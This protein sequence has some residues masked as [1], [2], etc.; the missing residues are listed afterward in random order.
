MRSNR[1]TISAAIAT[2]LVSA[3]LYPVFSGPAWFWA[4]AGATV[5]IAA[6]GT[7]T[8]LRRLPV[9]AC[10]LGGAAG[11]LLYLNLVFARSRS[12]LLVIPTPSSLAY[13]W[14]LAGQGLN[15]AAAYAPPAPELAGLVLLA[16]AGIG[17]TALL[18][19]LIAVR[20][21]SAAL[22][23]L[24]LLLLFCEPFTLSISRGWLGT[25]A[26]FCLAAAGYLTI[27]GAEGRERV[28]EWEQPLP[29]QPAAS[30]AARAPDTRALTAAGRRVG[31]ASVIVALCVPMFV[32]GL[33]V[34]RLFGGSA[35]IGGA[36][37]A[38][39]GA[40]FP[41]IQDVVTS[42]LRE[43][44]AVPVL[45]YRTSAAQPGY[46][47]VYVLD[48]LTD[49]GWQPFAQPESLV[50]V[51]PRLPPAPGITST[52]PVSLVTTDI[53]V[54]PGVPPDALAALAAPYPAVSVR[55]AAGIVRAD[56]GTLMIFDDGARL[57]GLS[58]TVTSDRV[59]PGERALA[60]VP[61]AAPAQIRD[62]YLQVPRAY[63]AL[64]G[65]ARDI[66]A[67]ARSPYAEAVALQDYFSDG[68][69]AY[70]LSA[71]A[72]TTE[73]GLANFLETT[74]TGY[75]VQ[76]ASAMAVLARLLGIPSRVVYG[77]TQGKH[78]SGD[79]WAVTTQD[80]HAWPELYFEGYGW[81]RFEPT[82]GG[83]AGQGTAVAPSYTRQQAAAAGPSSASTVPAAPVPSGGATARSGQPSL[84]KKIPGLDQQGGQGTAGAGRGGPGP[85]PL[86]GLSLLGLLAL[87]TAV[88]GGAR[89]LV[90]RRRW[91]RA[92]RDGDAG[93]A[94]AAWLEL[95]DDLTDYG[96]GYRP[97]ETPR[98][99]AARMAAG[100]DPEA[101][102]ALRRVTLAAERARY[103]ARPVPGTGLRQDSAAVRRALAA[104]ASRRARWR[105]RV[106]PR[107]VIAPVTARVSQVT[108]AFGR[109]S[110]SPGLSPG[111]SRLAS[112][113][114]LASRPLPGERPS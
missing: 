12:L 91:R 57:G 34:T 6:A 39:G 78:V 63:L 51:A 74:H 110:L 43:P 52:T 92:R 17:L 102:E 2:V 30:A 113:A 106:F 54:A 73:A 83:P 22:A 66:T 38:A 84:L 107:S 53:T 76:F 32:P 31:V 87:L 21:H 69:F 26:V 50:T 61:L 90:R 86:A 98:A 58:Y 49:S 5:T 103:S 93:M 8:R 77:F 99:L 15:Q 46:L 75:C 25:T 37:G 97:S 40:G 114:G 82:P 108:D 79:E 55:A 62:H 1:R 65:L 41:S 11:L 20:L 9:A 105:A 47:Q 48:D 95:R 3:A 18:T 81:L 13:L 29:G 70:S 45:T 89:A 10:A 56:R 23:G 94:R 28:R 67:G 96:A 64:S 111:L 72:F 112:R 71:P 60:A 7:L 27:L 14:H 4:G 19:D 100:T 36:G 101:G 33:H 42:E 104:A 68:N 85:W 109:L 80:A 59:T 16:A 44:G 35:G 88:P 24:P